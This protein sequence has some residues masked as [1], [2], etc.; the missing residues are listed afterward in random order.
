VSVRPAHRDAEQA[1]GQHVRGRVAAAEVGGSRRRQ[2]AVRALRSTQPE[3][4]HRRPTGGEDDVRRLGRRERRVV[5]EVEQR[6]LQQLRLEQGT[7][8]PQQRLVREDE[9]ALGHGVDVDPQPEVA[10]VVQE[11]PLEQRLVVVAEEALEMRELGG[12]ERIALDERDHALEPG[13][14]REAATERRVAE[15]QREDR[16]LVEALELPVARGHRQLVEVG[17]R[18]RRDGVAVHC[19]AGAGA[20]GHSIARAWAR[21]G[22]SRVPA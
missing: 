8:D 2:P 5:H 17:H 18:R 6:A 7:R 10:Q 1:A 20:H 11:R 13:R 19:A 15:E 3:L 16:L 9:G 4:H 14:Q 21:D 22:R 12:R